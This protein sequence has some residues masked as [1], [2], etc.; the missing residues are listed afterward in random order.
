MQASDIQSYND[1]GLFPGPNESEQ[2][3]IKRVEHMQNWSKQL[4][5]KDLV[6]KDLPYPLRHQ[7][8]MSEA[9]LR[10]SGKPILE[11]FGIAPV[12]VPAY[13]SDSGLPFLTGGM[14]VQ[15]VEHE[16]EPLKTFFQLKSVFKTQKKWLI[17]TADELIRHE[18][19]HVARVSLD[20]TRYEETFAY[21]TSDS[22]L[23]KKI[24]GALTTPK[25]NQLILLSLFLWMCA[26]FLP[27]F[28]DSIHSWIS[29]F[30]LPFPVL[31]TLGLVRNVSIR[32]ELKKSSFL[33]QAHFPYDHDK[34]LFRLN[35]Q[36]I[37]MLS[38]TP[39]SEIPNWWNSLEGFRGEFL[40]SAYCLKD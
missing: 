28:L 32:N 13:Y 8:R 6:L 16:N 22:W 33:L 38:K 23:R 18:M 9:Q 31:V 20:S 26:T 14:A 12:W 34:I 15:F 3:F 19:C 1:Q 37:S 17:Y 25:D 29:L 21:S 35:D 40:R 10:E 30:Y 2:D 27:H 7:D 39:S 4:K 36:E 24:G 5:N 11:K